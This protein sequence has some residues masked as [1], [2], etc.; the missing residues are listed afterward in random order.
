MHKEKKINKKFTDKISN[1]TFIL[2]FV[3]D[4]TFI[5]IQNYKAK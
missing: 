2:K 3:K 5:K 1:H 4:S